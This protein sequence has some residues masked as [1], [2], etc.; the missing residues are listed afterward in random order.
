M[1]R[2][3]SL[4]FFFLTLTQEREV[5][6]TNAA[7]DALEQKV[8]IS[9]SL[10]KHKF[11]EELAD[12]QSPYYQ[13]VAAKSQLQVSEPTSHNLSPGWDSDLGANSTEILLAHLPETRHSFHLF[14]YLFIYFLPFDPFTH[15]SYLPPISTSDNHQSIFCIYELGFGG[16]CG[17]FLGSIYT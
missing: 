16:V 2:I 7:E 12:S 11:K 10:A 14:I 13:E 5:E 6:S 4:F 15:F 9:V 8:E 17:L 3:P 1:N